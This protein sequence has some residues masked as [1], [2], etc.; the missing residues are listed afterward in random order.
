MKTP[1]SPAPALSPRLGRGLAAPLGGWS[2]RGV[3]VLEWT[4]RLRTGVDVIDDQHQE[5]FLRCARLVRALT[6]GDRS[7]VEPLVR[8]LT[9]YV[10]S[11]FEFEERWMVEAGYPGL[12]DHREAHGRFKEELREM[13]R[14]YQRKGPTPLMALTIHNWLAGWLQGHIGGADVELGRWATARGESPLS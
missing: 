14:E 13:T 4:S 11:H 6:A 9:D 5:L 3:P 12:P 8:Y 1:V 7:E 2:A 10:V